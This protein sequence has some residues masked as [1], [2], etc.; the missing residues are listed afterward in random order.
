MPQL[1]LW[2]ATGQSTSSH[3]GALYGSCELTAILAVYPVK[4]DAIPHFSLLVGVPWE[5]V[6]EGLW[7]AHRAVGEF[8][9]MLP[10]LIDHAVCPCCGFRNLGGL[11]RWHIKD[12]DSACP[13]LY[14]MI[15]EMA[16][17]LNGGKLSGKVLGDE[18]LDS[19]QGCFWI[20]RFEEQTLK[21][22]VGNA[23]AVMMVRAARCPV[24]HHVR[25]LD[26]NVVSERLDLSAPHPSPDGE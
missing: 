17:P 15:V 26:M 11:I 12:L 7:E 13:D 6:T 22:L 10:Q 4:N 5:L 3:V 18:I 9:S 1:A 2:I 21:N 20:G 8:L 25:C 23:F 16:V 24:R 19:D 14:L